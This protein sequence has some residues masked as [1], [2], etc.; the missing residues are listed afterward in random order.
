MQVR[1]PSTVQGR[2]TVQLRQ[3][4]DRPSEFETGKKTSGDIVA[5]QRHEGERVP[6]TSTQEGRSRPVTDE[7]DWQA[8]MSYLRQSVAMMS[9]RLE[10]LSIPA[11]QHKESYQ[12][13]TSGKPTGPGCQVDRRG[14]LQIEELAGSRGNA[15]TREEVSHSETTERLRN[16]CLPEDSGGI[17]HGETSRQVSRRRLL[18]RGRAEAKLLSDSE[19]DSV[20][21]EEVTGTRV[22]DRKTK[23]RTYGKDRLPEYER[24]DRQTD[25][26]QLAWKE[27]HERYSKGQKPD[28]R[29]RNCSGTM[30]LTDRQSQA[31]EILAKKTE[32]LRSLAETLRVLAIRVNGRITKSTQVASLVEKVRDRLST[33]LMKK[34]QRQATER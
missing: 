31:R 29:S 14:K 20:D 24:H 7:V 26:D 8:E 32:E 19:T 10:E 6:F 30:N 3:A 16:R 1:A 33:T 17:S 9:S 13:E 23:R 4:D 25:R 5:H 34:V 15:E 12:R 2:Q 18:A 11:A 21:P 22:F 27:T 28:S